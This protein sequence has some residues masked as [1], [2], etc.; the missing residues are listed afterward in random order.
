[1]DQNHGQ[2]PNCANPNPQTNSSYEKLDEYECPGVE[3]DCQ[4][5]MYRM[6][7]GLVFLE[8]VDRDED[9]I[10]HNLIAQNA[11]PR[12][13]DADDLSLSVAQNIK[14]L[15]CYGKVCRL[16]KLIQIVLI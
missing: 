12:E 7:G 15:K 11:R 10:E 4:L 16:S 1:M 14:A 9:V 3:C 8:K 6:N 5:V 2:F 13:R